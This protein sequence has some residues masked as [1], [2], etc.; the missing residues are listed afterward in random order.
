LYEQKANSA[1]MDKQTKRIPFQ[2]MKERQ[3][4]R[5]KEEASSPEW[6]RAFGQRDTFKQ[7]VAAQQEERRFCGRD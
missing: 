4:V 5:R 7:Q 1:E 6:I 2:K 3:E